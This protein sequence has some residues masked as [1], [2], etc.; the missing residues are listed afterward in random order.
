[1]RRVVVTGMGLVSPFGVGRGA[2][3]EADSDRHAA[4]RDASRNSEVDDLACKI[5][6]VD[7]AR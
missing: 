3:L 7:S 4:R 1:M 5:A 6:H 2:R